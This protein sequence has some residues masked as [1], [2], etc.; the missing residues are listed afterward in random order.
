MIRVNTVDKQGKEYSQSFTDADK[1]EIF[2]QLARENGC[3]VK[4][5]GNS[6]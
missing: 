3:E 2:A 4:V 5:L 6:K 1:A